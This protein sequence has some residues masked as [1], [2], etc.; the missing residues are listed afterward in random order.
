VAQDA[1][2]TS[3][4]DEVLARVRLALRDGARPPTVPRAYRRGAAPDL[5]TLVELLAERLVDYKS[6]VRHVERAAIATTVDEVCERRGASRVVIPAGLPAQWRPTRVESVP[7]DGLSARRLEPFDGVV[8]GCTVA[9]AETGTLV[10]S[11]GAAEGRR[12]ITLIPD[13]HVCVVLAEQIVDSVPAAIARLAS[14][15]PF[16]TRPITMVSGPSAT[17]DIELS[18]VEGVHGPRQL[19]VL[20]AV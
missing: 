16:R 15:A 6:E 14:L 18:R 20:I 5:A 7:D 4:R 1:A 10:L 11:A 2:M 3:A 13:L 9:I 12:L 17:S 8:T 19:V